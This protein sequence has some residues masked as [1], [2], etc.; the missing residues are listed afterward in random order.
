MNLINKYSFDLA[1]PEDSENILKVRNQLE[2][3][4]SAFNKHIITLDEH[5]K[6]FNKQLNSNFFHY[7]VLKNNNNDFIGLGYG[8]RFNKSDNSCFWG[9]RVITGLP[10]KDKAGSI[11]KYLT[12]E[13]LFSLKKIDKIYGQVIKGYEWIRDWYIRWGNELINFDEKKQCYNL[14]LRKDKWLK[15]KKLILK[16]INEVN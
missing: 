9:I 6:W 2:T 3:R 14:V 12:Y 11:V 7:Y 4:K 1:K 10:K 8:D 15:K 5:N 16:K 13:K